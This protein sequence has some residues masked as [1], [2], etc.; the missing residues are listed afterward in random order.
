MDVQPGYAHE[1]IKP[2]ALHYMTDKV[3][4]PSE[5]RPATKQ[6]LDLL[7]TDVGQFRVDVDQRFKEFRADVDQRFDQ[8]DKRFEQVDRRFDQLQET[9]VEQMRN[10]QT[11]V[12]RAFYTWARPFE[13]R[14][15]TLPQIEERLG[16]LE[17]RVS[18]L[19]RGDKV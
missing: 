4:M 19:E 8:V 1:R 7:R 14:M 11:E 15:R 9:L 13:L 10:M 17:E 3:V 2:M 16:L 12:L 18:S 6:D 5:D